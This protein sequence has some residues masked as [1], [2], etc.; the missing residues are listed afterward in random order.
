[1]KRLLA[2]GSGAIY[3]IGKAWRDGEVGRLHEPEFTLLE[4][5]RPG[6]DDAALMDE[7]EELVR[8]LSQ[9]FAP[10]GLSH[11]GRSV[12]TA[13]PFERITYREAFR[14]HTG[15]DPTT[16]EDSRFG[17]LLR[18]G[19]TKPPRDSNRATLE[20]LVLALVVQPELGLDRPC[21]VTDWPSDRA[22][23]A[24]LRPGRDPDQAEAAARFELYV[25]GVELCN[26][27]HELCDAEEQRLR[28]EAENRLRRTAGKETYP[29][30]EGFLAALSSG[31]PDCAGNAL[32]IDRLV[33]V[34]FGEEDLSASRSFRLDIRGPS[35][36]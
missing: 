25:A 21:F 26:G 29:I 13:A 27:Y 15:F 32:G 30:D 24:R 12:S 5:Y 31:L 16:T 2:A 11:R 4:W 7:C 34:L 17:R 14:R 36:D 28:I 33:L 19:G 35:C 8:S 9:T 22:A 3:Q 23:L 10:D 20:D 6:F 1:M 18:A